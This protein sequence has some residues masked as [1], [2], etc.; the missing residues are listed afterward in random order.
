MVRTSEQ[1]M[2]LEDIQTPWEGFYPCFAAPKIRETYIRLSNVELNIGSNLVCYIAMKN[3]PLH[4]LRLRTR[5]LG[6]EIL[7][8]LFEGVVIYE[9]GTEKRTLRCN[10]WMEGRHARGRKDQ[11]RNFVGW[12]NRFPADDTQVRCNQVIAQPPVHGKS[13][14]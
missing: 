14:F 5:A 2:I 6:V 11:R 7:N 9:E 12:S 1:K 13:L 4:H 3:L 8:P 10:Q